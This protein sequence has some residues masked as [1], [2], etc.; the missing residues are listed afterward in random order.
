MK[1]FYCHGLSIVK[2]N[3]L[4]ATHPEKYLKKKLLTFKAR[5]LILLAEKK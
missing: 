5:G 2:V 4:L 1:P 3:V